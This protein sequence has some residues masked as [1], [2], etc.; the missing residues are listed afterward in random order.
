MQKGYQKL[1]YKKSKFNQSAEI[2]GYQH[3]YPYPHHPNMPYNYPF[4]HPTPYFGY[5]PYYPPINYPY[6]QEA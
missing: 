6:N 1:K 2:K 4:M 3:N 5:Q